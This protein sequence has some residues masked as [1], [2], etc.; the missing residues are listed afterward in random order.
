MEKMIAFD[1]FKKWVKGRTFNEILG[2]AKLNLCG[3][4]LNKD[5]D[6]YN[7]KI[8]CSFHYTDETSG[9]SCMVE[10]IYLSNRMY[11]YICIDDESSAPNESE[12]SEHRWRR[13]ITE[14]IG[15]TDEDVIADEW[16][17]F[18][19]TL[20]DEVKM[21]SIEY[22][23]VL[24]NTDY[25]IKKKVEGFSE[26]MKNILLSNMVLSNYDNAD[27]YFY[28]TSDLRLEST[29]TIWGYM[30]YKGFY[31]YLIR[32]KFI[33]KY[34]SKWERKDTDEKQKENEWL[35][36]KLNNGD[37]IYSNNLEGYLS[38]YLSNGEEYTRDI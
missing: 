4:V 5:V 25:N 9:C 24:L 10:V 32:N 38:L 23:K 15:S 21:Y 8:A 3:L 20:D 2:C 12:W 27:R 7:E 35:V 18:V 31:E 30:E 29:D 37:M 36:C 22:N 33:I 6:E 34:G 13:A 17:K 14:L 19:D 26:E 28:I 11:T 16:N 1:S